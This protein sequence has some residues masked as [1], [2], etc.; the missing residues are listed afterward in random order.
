LWLV[1]LIAIFSVIGLILVWVDSLK[2]S[3]QA[4]V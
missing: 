3:W 4:G 1:A 2:P